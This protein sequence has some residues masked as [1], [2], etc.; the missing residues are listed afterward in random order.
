MLPEGDSMTRIFEANHYIL[1]RSGYSDPAEHRHMAAH[2]VIS[3]SEAMTVYA[4]DTVLSCR[5]VMIPSGISHRIDT[6]SRDTLVFLFA[7]SSNIAARIDAVRAVTDDVCAKVIGWYERLEADGVRDYG[8]HEQELLSCLGMWECYCTVTDER[9][10]RAMDYIRSNASEKVTC[11]DVADH[12]YL[13]QDRFSHLFR[14]EV[15]MTYAAYVVCQRMMRVYADVF[16]GK[17]I[18][19]AA[20]AAGFSGS[21]HFADVNRRVFGMPIGKIMEN[22]AFVKLRQQ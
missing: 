6:R 3:L 19:E 2:M 1:I 11:R 15:G 18:T 5:G 9:I 7:A 20:L 17:S 12:I 4:G 8:C 10:L 13:S 22:A 14:Q 16:Q 21:S